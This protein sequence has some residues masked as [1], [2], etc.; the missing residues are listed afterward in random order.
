MSLLNETPTYR[1]CSPQPTETQVNEDIAKAEGEEKTYY[2][3]VVGEDEKVSYVHPEVWSEDETYYYLKVYTEE[4][5]NKIDIESKMSEALD[6]VPGLLETSFK[7]ANPSEEDFNKSIEAQHF[8]IFDGYKY[9]NAKSFSEEDVYY[10]RLY[11]LCEGSELEKVE[12]NP[13]R[14][15]LMDEHNV[16]YKTSVYD[17][18]LQYYKA[19][20]SYAPCEVTVTEEMFNNDLM[21][22]DYMLK[23]GDSYRYATAWDSSATYYYFETTVNDIDTALTALINSYLLG[24]EESSSSSEPSRSFVA[25]EDILTLTKSEQELRAA[26]KEFVLTFIPLEQLDQVSVQFGTYVPFVLLGIIAFFALPWVWFAF[27]TIIR[28]LRKKKVWTRP[29]IVI[30]WAFPQVLL[31]LVITHGTKYAIPFLAEKIEI[32]KTYAQNFNLNIE[33]GCLIPSYVYLF[34]LGFSIVYAIFKHPVKVEYKQ[35]KRIR[36]NYYKMLRQRRYE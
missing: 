25:R 22:S 17:S 7:L 9:V 21:S 4:D 12:A 6:E 19:L 34:I 18:S 35:E 3:K 20:D 24:K 11:S 2:I 5:I 15:F 26:I 1:E 29:W 27:I 8:Y 23:D 14:Y 13:D 30:F 10:S 28:T 16:F 32:V 31:G 36:K 33:T